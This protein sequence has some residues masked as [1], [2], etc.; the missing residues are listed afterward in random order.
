MDE[1]QVR[2]INEQSIVSS[3][4]IDDGQKGYPIEISEYPLDIK[5]LC[6]HCKLIIRSPRQNQCGH[7]FCLTCINSLIER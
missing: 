6:T 3:A 1:Q 4:S 2:S 7:R 5:F